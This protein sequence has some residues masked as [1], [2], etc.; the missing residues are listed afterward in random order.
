MACVVLVYPAHPVLFVVVQ[1]LKKLFSEI[2]MYLINP[3]R[4]I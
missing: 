3:Q 2:D 1:S 4:E